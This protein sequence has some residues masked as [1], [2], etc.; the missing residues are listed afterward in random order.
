MAFAILLIVGA[1]VLLIYGAVQKRN[2]RFR[3]LSQGLLITYVMIVVPLI[4]GEIYFRYVYAD[5][6]MEFALT[7]GNW[8]RRYVQKNSLGWRDREWTA[9]DLQNKTVV[10]AVGDSFTEGWGINDPK[11]RYTDVLATQLGAEYAVVNLGFRGVATLHQVEAV[12]NY[13]YQP[14]DVVIWQYFINDID[15][16]AKSNGMT[17]SQPTVEAPQIANESYLASFVF[18]RLNESVLNVNYDGQSQWDYFYE[19]YDN[20]YIWDI[21]RQ[22]IDRMI[23]YV[24][25]VDARLIMVIFP[26]MVDPVGSIAYVDRVAQ[27]VE[28]KGH[29]DI[30]KLFEAAAEWKLEE[31]IVASYDSHASAAFN[32][33]VGETLYERFFKS[34]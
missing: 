20:A 8:D 22:E 10:F 23:D 31:R 15:V 7:G 13:P 34:Q 33:Y 5:P 29:S 27:Y 4:A 11:D 17:W 21:H 32:R 9:E 16:A 1:G 14:P 25:S 6:R 18:W 28:S 24:Q 2:L 30:L 3:S 19:A 12:E 26:H